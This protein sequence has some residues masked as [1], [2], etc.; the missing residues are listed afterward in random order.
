MAWK[1]GKEPDAAAIND[2]TDGPKND[3]LMIYKKL[4]FR[5]VLICF[6]EDEWF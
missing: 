2:G 4:I 3:G 5:M 6:F 1:H